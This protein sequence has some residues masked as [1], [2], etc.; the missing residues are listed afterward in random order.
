MR[1]KFIFIFSFLMLTA[2]IV[3]PAFAQQESIT[4]TTYYPAPYGVYRTL[5]LFPVSDAEIDISQPCAAKGE[6][7]M[8]DS[9]NSLYVCNGTN[10]QS[11][12][13]PTLEC[14]TGVYRGGKNGFVTKD[15]F[16]PLY[17]KSAD[18][19]ALYNDLATDNPSKPAYIINNSGRGTITDAFRVLP[20]AS[21]LLFVNSAK[22]DPKQEEI[23]NL[24]KDHL[25]IETAG[26]GIV[27]PTSHDTPFVGSSTLEGT[28]YNF[29]DVFTT[30]DVW[31]T[32]EGDSYAPII[33]CRAENG[34]IATGCG[35]NTWGGAGYDE[36][37]YLLQNGCKGQQWG[38]NRISVRCCR[39]V[40]TDL[41]S[42]TF[43]GD[44]YT[45]TK[46]KGIIY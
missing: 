45:S 27:S 19:T 34:W 7:F 35:A 36:D 11:V 28:S 4:I 33:R 24:I 18:R 21:A 23:Y 38:D 46:G 30:E 5:R 29:A 26:S 37:E 12:S 43:Y 16:K 14:I 39:T 10:W 31:E 22:F 20:D 8:R 32:N 1:N 3:L 2:S 42:F 40:N 25:D 13:R 41:E 9:D 44:S 17:S 15:M 6:L